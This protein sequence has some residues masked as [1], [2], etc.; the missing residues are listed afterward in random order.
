MENRMSKLLIT[1]HY[2]QYSSNI[3]GIVIMRGGGNVFN[4]SSFL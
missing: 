3:Y 4:E 1:I 2:K